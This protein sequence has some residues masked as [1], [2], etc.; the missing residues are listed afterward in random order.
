MPAD[1]VPA[2]VPGCVHTDL[3]RAGVIPDPFL[4]LNE[5]QVQW[6]ALADWR[7]ETTFAWPDDDSRGR[8]DLVFEGLDTIAAVELNGVLVARTA[9]MHRT[10][11]FDLS[12]LLQTENHLM[13]TFESPVRAADRASEVLGRRPHTLTHPYNAIRKMACSFGWDWG[14]DLATSGIW[15]PVSLQTWST[16]RLASVRPLVA[17]A[18]AQATVGVCV[19]VQRD[20]G[21]DSDL[22]VRARVG[23]HLEHGIVRAGETTTIVP[24]TVPEPRLWWPAGY[25]EQPLYQVKVELGGTQVLDHWEGRVG[26]RTVA[27]RTED[28]AD[29]TGFVLA[30]NDQPILVKGANWIPEDSFLDRLTPQ[31]YARRLTDAV[32]AGMNLL[33]VWGGGIFESDVFYDRCDEMGLL[34]WQDF[35]FACAAYAEEEPLRSEVEAEARD[36]IA[37]LV[38]H[39]SLALW[40]GNNENLWGYVDWQWQER[41][42]DR[43]WGWGYYTDLLPRLVAELDGTRPYCPGSPWSPRPGMHPNDPA[44]GSTHLWEVWNQLDYA[45]YRNYR[46]RFVSEFGWQGPPSWTTLTDSVHDDPLTP[47]S[48]GVLAHQKA[49]DGNLKLERGLSPHLPQPAGTADYHWAM[50]LN[51]ARALALGLEHFRSLAPSCSGAVVWQLNDCWPVVSWSLVDSAGRRKPAWYAVRKAFAHRL[52][53]VQPEPDGLA[54]HVCNDHREIWQ[55]R[56]M[57]QRCRFDGTVLA[58]HETTMD[59]P[60]RANRSLRLTDELSIPGDPASELLVVTG[61][62][63]DRAWWFFVEDRDAALPPPALTATMTTGSPGY[64]LHLVAQSLV[65]D[66]T[67]LVDKAAPD[68]VADQALLTMLPGE[69]T[70]V[71]VRTQQSLTEQALLDPLVLRSANQLL[72]R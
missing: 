21:A 61:D 8:T 55:A 64:Q 45:A 46:P 12:G 52:L 10:Y 25:G 11:R 33:R 17:M 5:T 19:E 18:G 67:L 28:D 22:P 30:V 59:V 1:G 3:L 68:A 9:N 4:D 63:V 6:V 69:Q 7:Y 65:K 62:A 47:E 66:V 24:V 56:I 38:G 29:G 57:V 23:D 2:Q 37:R 27:L 42:D 16:A 15:R 13:V 20:D 53:T 48:P 36:N 60:A 31:R 26:L 41:L 44:Q 39:P 54:V 72:H 51:Q 14:P 32:D 35:L 34:V 40:N 71:A 50:Q 49:A 58:A 70:T 43:S